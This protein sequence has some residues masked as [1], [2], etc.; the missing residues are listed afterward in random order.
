MARKKI[1]LKHAWYTILNSMAEHL[2]PPSFML[3]PAGMPKKFTILKAERLHE[4]LMSIC[5]CKEALEV[6]K[7]R[8][9]WNPIFRY[10]SDKLHLRD[11]DSGVARY[12]ST[13]EFLMNYLEKKEAKHTKKCVLRWMCGWA[14]L[15]LLSN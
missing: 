8:T 2:L 15:Q 5:P 7:N 12:S 11:F 4:L 9:L 6:E 13:N 14:K 1:A 10:T 3:R